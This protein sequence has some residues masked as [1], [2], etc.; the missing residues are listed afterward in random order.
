[1]TI[2]ATRE[3]TRQIMAEPSPYAS[4]RGESIGRDPRTIDPA[5]FDAAGIPLMLANA[6]IRARCL[7]CCTGQEAEVRKCVAA[8]CPLW[9]FRMT[10]RLP[11]RL[12]QAA[13]GN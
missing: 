9:P 4:D 5:D 6:A 1:M 8:S 12:K 3:R 13:L 10:G 11:P 7:E 2:T